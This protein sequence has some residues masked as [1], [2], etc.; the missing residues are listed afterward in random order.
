MKFTL[1]FFSCI[2]I[3]Q[4]IQFYCLF[5]PNVRYIEANWKYEEKNIE[6]MN[7]L[8]ILAMWNRWHIS[9]F[10]SFSSFL[11][12]SS[13]N[14]KNACDCNVFFLYLGYIHLNMLLVCL[15][16]LY[17]HCCH[18]WWMKATKK[19]CITSPELHHLCDLNFF[20]APSNKKKRFIYLGL[21]ISIFQ[22]LHS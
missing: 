16:V 17:R 1:F 9:I 7:W 18:W 14:V 8:I 15:F 12:I 6:M 13:V 10:S 20:G 21:F 4:V 5:K 22:F 19:T 11:S 3:K 2:A